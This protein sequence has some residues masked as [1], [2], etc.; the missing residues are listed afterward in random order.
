[1]KV[2]SDV[3]RNP[4]LFIVIIGKCPNLLL[5]EALGAPGSPQRTWISCYAAPD[6]TA[7]A[8][9]FEES[10]MQF[11]N[12]TNLDRKSGG[13]WEIMICFH[14]FPRRAQRHLLPRHDARP[15]C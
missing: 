15:S 7:C 11:D 9:F 10:R 5:S 14:C 8:A 13:T 2:A 4:Q 12:A 1:M 6:R 3:L